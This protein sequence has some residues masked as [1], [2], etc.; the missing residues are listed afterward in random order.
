MHS[1]DEVQFMMNTINAETLLILEKSC[2]LNID[3]E[4][5]SL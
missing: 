1:T 4:F 3:T 2:I 5:D